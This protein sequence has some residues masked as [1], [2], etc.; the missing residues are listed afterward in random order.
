MNLHDDKSL[1]ADAVMA[2][3]QHTG[4]NPVYVE[5]DYWITRSLKLLSEV[6]KNN[7]A[8]FK[9]GTSLSK[10]HLIGKRFS[11]DIDIAISE[12]SSLMETKEKCL[13][14]VLQKQ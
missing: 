9:G 4:I 2:C 13:S 12:A 8:I 1:F 5:K 3:S 7:R 6:D 11:E 10:V 14:N